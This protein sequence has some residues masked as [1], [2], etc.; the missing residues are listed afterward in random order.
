MIVFEQS[1]DS[2][3]ARFMMSSSLVMVASEGPYVLAYQIRDDVADWLDEHAPGW[4]EFDSTNPV[5]QPITCLI[6]T[7]PEHCVAFQL[8]WG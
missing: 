7:R 1:M 3:I 6:L 8:R 2:Y 5:G 4:D